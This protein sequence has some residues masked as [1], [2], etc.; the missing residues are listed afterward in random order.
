[1]LCCAKYRGKLVTIVCFCSLSGQS[2]LES[3]SEISFS[4]SRDQYKQ[5]VLPGGYQ[6]ILPTYR[7][8]CSGNITEWTVEVNELHNKYDFNFQVWR[9]SPTK[10]ETQRYVLIGQNSAKEVYPP[11][12]N[13][14]GI[15]RITV[16]PEDQMQFQP[17]DVVGVYVFSYLP[18]S[19]I[20]LLSSDQ[21]DRVLEEVWY[22]NVDSQLAVGGECTETTLLETFTNALP[23]ISVS[24]D[25]AIDNGKYACSYIDRTI[26]AIANEQRML[27]CQHFSHNLQILQLSHLQ[28][29]TALNMRSFLT[30]KM[31]STF[32]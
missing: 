14:M 9:P 26:I 30:T 8:N 29:T 3:N 5:S 23:A 18:K 1:M 13:S 24:V 20:I 10:D 21:G 19:G 4:H 17:G 28:Q 22:A 11:E 6:A 27:K 16:L 12:K 7:F 32:Q 31:L 15:I 2:C 25:I